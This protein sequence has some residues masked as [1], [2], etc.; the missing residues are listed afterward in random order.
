MILEVAGYPKPGNVHR[1]QDFEDTRFEHFLA[2]AI[3][4]GCI[5]EK[6]ATRGILAGRG[7]VPISQIG[8][9]RYINRCIR[10][11]SEWHHGGNTWLGTVM[12]LVP[13]AVGAGL[14]GVKQGAIELKPLRLAVRRV[15][16]ATTLKDAVYLYKA[17]RRAEAGG[18]G[19]VEDSS[20]PDINSPSY[21]DEIKAKSL[22]LYNVMKV[23]SKWDTI[24][25]EW[26]T[27]LEITFEVGYPALMMF[28]NKTHDINV[29][30]V[31]TFLTILAAIP[32]TL[33]ARKR[34]IKMAEK[35]SAD[36]KDALAKGGLLTEEGKRAV[37][38]MD[39]ELR[40]PRNSINPGT[41]ADLTASSLMVAT[42]CG[43]RP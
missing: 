11:S 38:R 26:Q 3:A 7:K 30:T 17:V 31:H 2:S 25:Q 40:T 18:L 1:L 6:A 9:G 36:A 32:D 28:Y 39:K 4:M 10:D 37:N 13:L 14:S 27:G 41:T 33:V 24:C 23:C 34:G 16:K 19:K 22:S 8:V 5:M 43:L 42:L 20:V 15:I 29:A 21:I 12:L 35:I